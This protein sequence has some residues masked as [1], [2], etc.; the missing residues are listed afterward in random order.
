MTD[1]Q[2][3]MPVNDVELVSDAIEHHMATGE[4]SGRYEELDRILKYLRY[5][6]ALNT[7]NQAR[8]TSE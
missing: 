5:R 6:I 8:T 1:L 7:A 3:R 4:T 2:F